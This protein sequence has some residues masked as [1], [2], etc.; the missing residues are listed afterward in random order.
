MK[1]LLLDTHALLWWL[2]DGDELGPDTRNLIAAADN[3]IYVSAISIW[4]I[5]IKKALGKL[6][7]PDDFAAILEAE[8]FEL[9]TPAEFQRRREKATTR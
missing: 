9:F 8:G 2:S 6:T 1:R 5:S 3:V 7:A 4:E